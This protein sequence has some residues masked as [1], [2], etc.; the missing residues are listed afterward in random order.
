MFAEYFTGD[1]NECI[2]KKPEK[3]NFNL[4]PDMEGV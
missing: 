1:C 3:R 2:T 4:Q